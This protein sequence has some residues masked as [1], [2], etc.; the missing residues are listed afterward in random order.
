MLFFYSTRKSSPDYQ[1]KIR[2]S[3]KGD[4]KVHEF[5]NEGQYSLTQA[6]NQALDMCG[7]DEI[8]VLGHDD[9]ILP[10]GW[11]EQLKKIFD[12]TDYGIIGA[13]GS[14]SMGVN[15]VWWENRS[16]LAGIVSHEKM[17][18]NKL[19]KYDTFFSDNH[20]FV[21]DVCVVD[22]VFIALKKDRIKARF[23]ENIGGFHFYDVSFSLENSLKGVKVGVTTAFKVH[24]KSVGPISE[25]WQK[26]RQVFLQEY[27]SYLPASCQPSI[28]QIAVQKPVTLYPTKIGVIILTKDKIDYVKKCITSL[29]EKTNPVLSLNIVVGDTGS[30]SDSL[31][32]L[33]DFLNEEKPEN[34]SVRVYKLPKYNFSK[35]NNDI[36]R[37]CF[38]DEE[39]ILFCNNDVELVNNALDLMVATYQSNRKNCGTV[40]CRL[41][42]P[43]L[44][45]QHA[46]IA[47]YGNKV[48]FRG[49][50]HF[51]L[52]SYYSGKSKP[53]NTFIGSTG[54]FLLIKRADF[55]KLNGFNEN[56]EE[57]FE[58][59][60]LNIETLA[61]LNKVNHY[62][63]DAVCI[64]YESLTRN[65]DPQQMQRL[66]KDLQNVL[67][68]KII[69]HKNTVQKFFIITP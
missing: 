64:H 36:V 1:N 69:Q 50:T 44:R 47:M 33:R 11:D 39:L 19:I 56:T 32:E 63:G 37:D 29:I 34:I 46:G 30:S 68:P 10:L 42:Y 62:Q 51:G 55:E 61:V 4:V 54:A 40:G 8:L 5:V 48:G 13:A 38:T 12:T 25:S 23:N 17:E 16:D 20:D 18:N 22:G 41:L 28:S 31:N 65:E 26:N 57:C 9:I 60:V 49:V 53:T 21:M 2:K 66:Q 35:N 58:D 27:G 7:D 67:I 14:A 24:H 45:V 59:V 52:K 15:G 6:Y 43:N 3:C